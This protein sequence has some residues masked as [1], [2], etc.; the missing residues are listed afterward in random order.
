MT[1]QIAMSVTDAAKA[2]GIGKTKMYEIIRRDD[3]DFVFEL[4]GRRLISRAKLE[5]WVNRQCGEA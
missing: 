1:E 3:A 5:E 4:D 2:I